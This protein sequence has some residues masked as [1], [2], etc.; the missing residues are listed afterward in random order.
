M[1]DQEQVVRRGPGG[2]LEVAEQRISDFDL[3]A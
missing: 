2:G 3:P 1:L